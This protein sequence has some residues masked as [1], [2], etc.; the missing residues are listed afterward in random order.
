MVVRNGDR[1]L[2]FVIKLLILRIHFLH[3][4]KIFDFLD[5]HSVFWRNG[6]FRFPCEIN[7]ISNFIG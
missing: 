2:Q 6:S 7:T 1:S 3:L 5:I 4:N